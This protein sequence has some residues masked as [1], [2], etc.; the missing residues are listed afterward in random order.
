MLLT[1]ITHPQ[2]AGAAR[3][4]AASAHPLWSH[5]R[6]FTWQILYNRKWILVERLDQRPRNQRPCSPLYVVEAFLAAIRRLFL[7]FHR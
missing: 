3:S 7:Q 5:F 6:T 1:E 4:A 2:S